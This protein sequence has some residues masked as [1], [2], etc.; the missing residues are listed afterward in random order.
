MEYLC[1]E[2]AGAALKS[3]R[4]TLGRIGWAL[5]LAFAVFQGVGAALAF[6]LERAVPGA[7]QDGWISLAVNMLPLY[8]LGM[9]LCWLMVRRLPAAAPCEVHGVGA[10]GLLTF[11]TGTYAVGYLLQGATLWWG[12][13]I[14]QLTGRDFLQAVPTY[15]QMSPLPTLLIAGILAPIL[16]EAVFRGLLLRRLLPYGRV[17]AT[18]ATAVLFGLFHG[19]FFQMFYAFGI[20]LVFAYITI[21]TG[22]LVY[23]TLMHIFF[24]SFN[25]VCGF[26]A[27]EYPQLAPLAAIP[28]V[29]AAVGAV[30]LYR[31]RH[32]IAYRLH[33]A[34]LPAAACLGR[35]VRSVGMWVFFLLCIGMSVAVLF[36]S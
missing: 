12:N 18:V 3:C 32:R 14:Y 8:L 30:L 10:V 17:F 16:E 6:W 5:G 21:R 33:P 9:P 31:V 27:L 25:A 22:S 36:L 11:F 34:P 13:L 1:F 24:N 26:L 4:R 23:A 2:S 20:G 29:F 35:M 19:N 7:M 15:D 28:L